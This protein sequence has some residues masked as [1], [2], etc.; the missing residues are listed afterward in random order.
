MSVCVCV[1]V[2]VVEA[3][4]KINPVVN[5]WESFLHRVQCCQSNCS[6]YMCEYQL[7]LLAVITSP[8]GFMAFLKETI[9]LFLGVCCKSQ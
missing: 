1:C 4:E 8:T 3:L 6:V 5:M 2:D 7:Y 9:S